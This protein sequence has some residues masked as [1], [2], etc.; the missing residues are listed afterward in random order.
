MS[1]HLNLYMAR[2]EVE[3]VRGR[4]AARKAEREA[5]EAEAP[6]LNVLHN[7]G[8]GLKRVPVQPMTVEE[9]HAS[10]PSDIEARLNELHERFAGRS[11]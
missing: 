1:A 5:I 11:A 6:L 9:M 4:T 7:K 10:M 2:Y 8:R 3:E